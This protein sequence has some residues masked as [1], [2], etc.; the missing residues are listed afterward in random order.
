MS[1]RLS[2]MLAATHSI[3]YAVPLEECEG[4]SSRSHS[5]VLS[6]SAC[7]VAACQAKGIFLFL[8]LFHLALTLDSSKRTRRDVQ[9]GPLVA[10]ARNSDIFKE[11]G[12][13]TQGER[14][15]VEFIHTQVLGE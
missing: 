9:W 12:V 5:V 15:D 8:V 6:F 11:E 10:G 7:E 4:N 3:L 13:E 2:L 1:Y 14:K